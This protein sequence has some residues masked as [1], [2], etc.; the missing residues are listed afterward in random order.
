MCRASS[1]RAVRMVIVVPSFRWAVV[2]GM[3]DMEMLLCSW[4]HCINCERELSTASS[5]IIL[6]HDISEQR[7]LDAVCAPD[8][9]GRK[10]GEV[11]RTRTTALQMHTRQWYPLLLTPRLL[12]VPALASLHRHIRLLQ[13]LD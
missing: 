11:V 10:R 8:Y 13:V 6:L 1:G 9:R 2:S 12:G 4:L 3:A 5:R 7:R